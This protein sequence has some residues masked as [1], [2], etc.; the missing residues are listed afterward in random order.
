MFTIGSSYLFAGNQDPELIIPKQMKGNKIDFHINAEISY[1]SISHFVKN[2]SK[3][4]F[5]QAWLKDKEVNRLSEQTDSLRRIYANALNDQKETISAL[6]LKDEA[7]AI[8]L[9]E[10]IPTLYEKARIIENQYWQSATADETAKF[11]EKIKAYR[12]SILLV[13]QSQTKHTILP[14]KEIPDTIIFYGSKPTP[15][16]TKTEESSGIV[17]KIQIGSY[18]SKVPDSA[19]KLIKKLSIL[20]K[21]E[22]YKDE[23]GFTIYTTG[24]LNKY[25]EAVTLQN[26]VK[27]EG[28]KNAIVEAYRNGKKITVADARKLNNE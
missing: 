8:A 18:K 9:N 25:A 15:A 16:E 10:E 3:K 22:N 28:V 7:Q 11:Q 12:D 4:L 1:F 27:Q 6:I 17:Y 21:I 23:K 5:I 2:E 13:N 24:S 26:Q 14:K 20:R 19:A